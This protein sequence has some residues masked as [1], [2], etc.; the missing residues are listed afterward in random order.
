V[1]KTNGGTGANADYILRD[2]ACEKWEIY[3]I[4]ET[5][6]Q[7][8]EEKDIKKNISRHINDFAELGRGNRKDYRVILS[9]KG[10]D[11]E[12]DKALSLAKEFVN[13]KFKDNKAII[14]LHSNTE[15]KHIHVLVSARQLNGKKLDLNNRQY[16][17]F[18]KA[19]GKIVD[20]NLEKGVLEEHLFKSA[21][22]IAY[23]KAFVHG[24]INT[25]VPNRSD[26]IAQIHIKKRKE[27]L[28]QKIKLKFK[29][30]K[31]DYL[32]KKELNKNPDYKKGIVY[33]LKKW[34]KELEK[35]KAGLIKSKTPSVIKI[36]K[37]E[38]QN[39]GNRLI[40]RGNY[41]E[42]DKIKGFLFNE[43]DYSKSLYFIPNK[44]EVW[45]LKEKQK[46]QYK[47]LEK[48][49]GFSKSDSINKYQ[50][51]E[52]VKS[53]IIQIIEKKGAW[54]KVKVDN[55]VFVL[56]RKGDLYSVNLE[57]SLKTNTFINKEKGKNLIHIRGGIER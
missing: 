19:W 25:P 30:I 28:I 27:N 6:K 43:K 45:N 44:E 24:L 9:F 34:N 17:S 40:K 8:I 54:E 20:K 15:N 26:S 18:D 38:R 42:L 53:R 47:L 32:L 1:G 46:Q 39:I 21:K 3:N 37:I 13:K 2:K 22:K 49:L 51:K 23:K 10:H 36:S 56:G 31:K 4:A 29:N 11:I 35:Y 12:S 50:Y 16:R 48:N 52:L 5:K 55:E 14:A 33:N 7:G 57:N 41:F